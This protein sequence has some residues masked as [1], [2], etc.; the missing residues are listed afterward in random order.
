MNQSVDLLGMQ[1][2][3]LVGREDVISNI[4]DIGQKAFFRKQPV[5]IRVRGKGGIGK[6][7]ILSEVR[8]YIK[9]NRDILVA[10]EIIDLYH[11][12]YQT[13]H[14]LAE[15]FAD[16]FPSESIVF[17]KF[18]YL[19]EELKQALVEHQIDKASEK[20]NLAEK[21]LIHAFEN[22]TKQRQIWLFLDTLDSLT[23]FT[24][25]AETDPG[26]EL[27]IKWL[28]KILN[29][30]LRSRVI[31]V[32]AERPL[33]DEQKV[34]R[35]ENF[36]LSANGMVKE[37][38]IDLNPLN[39]AQSREYLEHVAIQIENDDPVG[40]EN[41]ISYINTY[42]D[43]LLH[44]GTQGMPLLLAMVSDILRVGGS[45]PI[46]FY[47]SSPSV[48]QENIQK[49]LTDQFM[50]LRSPIGMTLRA[51]A[52]LRKGTDDKLLA[53][54]M[55]IDE[56]QAKNNLNQVQKLIL[57][58]RRPGEFSRQYFLH[59]EIYDL[60]F[61]RSYPKNSEGISSEGKLLYSKIS[62]YY[63]DETARLRRETREYPYLAGR[64]QLRLHMAQVEKMH[65]AVW[66]DPWLG[67]SEFFVQSS[68]AINLR[69]HDWDV[70]LQTEFNR[71]A[72]KLK[73]FTRYPK[74]LDDYVDW[75]YRI[76]EIDRAS[77]SGKPNSA[78][79][80]LNALPA[81]VDI[82]FLCSSYLWLV[83]ATLFTRGQAKPQTGLLGMGPEYC[84]DEADKSLKRIPNTASFN[85]A[86]QT[87]QAF[88]DNYR[89]FS[90]R[91]SG[92]YQQAILYY[93]NAAAIMRRLRMGSVG[94][95]LV[96]Q[97]YAM[98]MIG[99]D[100]RA[101]ETAREAYEKAVEY[102]SHHDQIRALTVRAS[103]E[104]L[105]GE[106][107][108]GEKFAKQTLSLLQEYPESRLQAFAYITFARSHRY[109]WNQ[110]VGERANE[111]YVEGRH[112][113]GTALCYLE[114]SDAILK[115]L[116]WQGLPDVPTG[117]ISTLQK[118]SSLEA[119]T[120][121]RNES[122]CLWRE[123]AW[124]L[125]KEFNPERDRDY[126]I[127]KLRK[128]CNQ[129]AEVRLRQATGIHEVLEEH[130]LQRVKEQINNVGGSPYWPMLALANL[131]WHFHYLRKPIADIEKLC[132]L[133]ERAIGEYAGLDYLW[134]DG[135]PRQ[136]TDDADV[137]LWAVLGKMEMLRGY[138]HLR[139]WHEDEQVIEIA[140]IHI[141]IA[142]EYNYL[143]GQT[144]FNMRRAEM[145]LENRIRDSK[146]WENDLFPRF[147]KASIRAG[148]LLESQN[149]RGKPRLLKWLEERFG[150][151]E[152]WVK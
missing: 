132:V 85:D 82:P 74:A 129:M 138:E 100:R 133:I 21:E 41:I 101:R 115:S 37:M 90:R 131:G 20:W 143:I 70:L 18:K 92:K 67:F 149:L 46:P 88:I 69:E 15:A 2:I 111:R 63:D 43:K 116:K 109:Q 22:L 80:L 78:E 26:T 98:S 5:V 4:L 51:L 86:I 84:L 40:H 55:Q 141:A 12:D 83:K 79:M 139:Y 44:F 112:L 16:A 56:Q 3:A 47:E 77:T 53:S 10:N 8:K 108:E 150:P 105:D 148:E 36:D 58:K 126:E 32:F 106:S 11:L 95:V 151:P 27:T 52:L 33:R 35:L 146:N 96:N 130:W 113:I 39:A 61:E 123:A 38:F 119:L 71:T 9:D 54:I 76:R 1:R 50:N 99:Y 30:L 135:P 142:L 60:Y 121:A 24:S 28:P 81:S 122:G 107:Q 118:I 104:N 87:I 64:N 144:S 62:A 13:S 128:Y 102:G 75:D 73:H 42:N 110:E 49:S 14:G 136:T 114:G 66:F 117:A 48:D 140:S 124:L 127:E 147:Y 57:V 59:D 152:A 72:A 19:M 103:I 68:N 94:G 89:G 23:H 93:Q 31:F 120:Q 25:L 29:E 6:T 7:A 97:A 65:Y 91:K 34:K 17:S 145:G 125:L 134:R 137:M 45:L